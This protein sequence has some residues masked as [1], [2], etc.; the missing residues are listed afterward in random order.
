MA[1]G[2]PGSWSDG[3]VGRDGGV[4]GGMLEERDACKDG[5]R[6][7]GYGTRRQAGS[8]GDA[9]RSPTYINGWEGAG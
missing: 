5:E 7:A 3:E 4:G 1:G 6:D 9:K 2:G 8:D